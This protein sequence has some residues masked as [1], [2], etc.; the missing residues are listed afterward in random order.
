MNKLTFSGQGS[1][2]ING[3]AAT[4]P[5]DIKTGDVIVAKAY[6]TASGPDFGSDNVVTI[7]YG[8]N[9]QTVS[10]WTEKTFDITAG[11]IGIT[12]D[13][14]SGDNVAQATINYTAIVK[15]SV[16]LTTLSGWSSLPDGTHNITVVAKGTGYADSAKSAAVEV[17]KRYGHQ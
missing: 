6:K 17:T 9:T 7:S 5:A 13:G 16:D 1:V 11:D 14:N 4:S 10:G 8:S 15:K 12:L 2:T 3:T